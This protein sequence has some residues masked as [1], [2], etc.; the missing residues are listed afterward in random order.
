M[1]K[2]I[3]KHILEIRHKPNSRFLDHRGEIASSLSGQKF[4]QWNIGNNRIDFVN[5]EH[6][7]V[8][9]FLT[10]QNLGFSSEHPNSIESFSNDAKNFL[11]DAWIHFPAN[12]ITR[13]GIR[14]TF[15][16]EVENFKEAFDKYKSTFLGLKE[17]DI[18]K[19]GG[20][21]IDLGFPL[22]FAVGEEF[23]NIT[24]GPMEKKEYKEFLMDASELPATGI[25]IDIDYFRKEFSPHVIQ[26]N[27]FDL[28]DRG[29][30]KAK[31]IEK[32]ISN[33]IIQ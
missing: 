4:N 23:F 8:W 24:T 7:D 5:K 22:N 12:Q 3:S 32:E 21:L 29:I 15:L 28:I 11:K 2:I 30:A 27:I 33:L 6:P 20:D 31:E 17:E 26:K 10:Y 19:F 9:A 14:S 25:Y 16:V 13:V 1:A 18:E